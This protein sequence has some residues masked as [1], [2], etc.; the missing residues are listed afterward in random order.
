MARSFF[1]ILIITTFFIPVAQK[2]IGIP[3][4][5][6]QLDGYDESSHQP[7]FSWKD[8][9]EGSFQE[10][11][12][13]YLQENVGYK[14][15]LIALK[16][17]IDYSLFNK[18][19]YGIEKGDGGQ[20]FYWNHIDTHC[21]HLSLSDDSLQRKINECVTLKTTLDSLHIKMLFVLAPGKPFFYEDKLPE[22][23]KTSC[24]ENNDYHHVLQLLNKNAL[25]VIDFNSWFKDLRDKKPYP[26]FPKLGTHWSYYAATI[27]I[28][29]LTKCLSRE[30]KTDLTQ[31]TLVNMKVTDQPKGKDKD[32]WS[33]LN[34]L[35]PM[36]S[37]SLAYPQYSYARKNNQPQKPKILLIGDSFNWTLLDTKI[38]PEYFSED[39]RFWFYKR[40][41]YDLN[42]R[43][44]TDNP[45][46]VNFYDLLNGTDCVIF[47]STE[48]LYHRLDHGFTNALLTQ[49]RVI[50][51]LKNNR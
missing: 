49:Q 10:N 14:G 12:T 6:Y 13:T 1:L 30:L 36:Q 5:D 46:D 38:L 3:T 34:V 44:I 18:L 27:A 37:D 43:W 32:L 26:L 41:L 21:G 48:V 15:Y 33:L 29:S 7:T 28:D 50:D 39:S 45:D 11:I 19:N 40:Q 25:P 24:S 35:L 4:K 17:Q 16:N 8:F 47:L 22:K 23:F 20:L 31:K 9:L 42:G 51:S 2:Y